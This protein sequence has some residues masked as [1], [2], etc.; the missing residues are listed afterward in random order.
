MAAPKIS[1]C[2]SLQEPATVLSQKLYDLTTQTM[3]QGKAGLVEVVKFSK[4]DA[5]TGQTVTVTIPILK[6]NNFNWFSGYYL[7]NSQGQRMEIRGAAGPGAAWRMAGEMVNDPRNKSFFTEK[8]TQTHEIVPVGAQAVWLPIGRCTRMDA[9]NLYKSL[10]NAGLSINP[11]RVFKKGDSN[12]FRAEYNKLLF[13]DNIILATSAVSDVVGFLSPIRRSLNLKG[14]N[15]QKNSELNNTPAKLQTDLTLLKKNDSIVSVKNKVTKVGGN[16]TNYA[17]V[18][19]RTDP[20]T[21]INQ[22]QKKISE[23]KSGRITPKQLNDALKITTSIYQ[24]PQTQFTT[25]QTKSFAQAGAEINYLLSNPP[26][27]LSAPSSPR[28]LVGASSLQR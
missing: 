21:V 11:I 24:A 6:D 12:L 22:L 5:N 3:A 14:K 18:F 19:S 26:A 25:Q 7:L 20:N 16:K 10:T 23:Y 27:K 2:Q 15:Q 8:R 13:A 1:S 17:P 28:T 9:I 4:L